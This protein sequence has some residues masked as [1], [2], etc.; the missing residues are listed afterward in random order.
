[1][2]RGQMRG[3]TKT[4]QIEELLPEESARH[5]YITNRYIHARWSTERSSFIHFDG[6]IQERTDP[7]DTPRDSRR[8]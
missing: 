7:T 3:E 4:V 2:I 5:G 8:T 6:A 1:M